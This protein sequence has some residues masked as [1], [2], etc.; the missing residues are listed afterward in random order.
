MLS[1]RLFLTGL[2]GAGLGAALGMPGLSFATIPG[3]ARF[4]LVILRGGMDGLAAFPPYADPH[5]RSARG[6]LALA[7]PGEENGVLDL[8][9]QFGM[10]P[11]LS[12]LHPFFQKQELL[13]F[14]AVAVAKPTRSHFDAQDILENGTDQAHTHDDG[15]LNRSLA[16]LGGGDQRLGLAV[17][18]DI[19]LV[20][21]GNTPVASWAPSR[22]A[23]APPGL[24][25]SL[26]FMYEDD[27]V[28]GPALRDG[29]RAKR[30]AKEALGESAPMS[31]GNPRGNPRSPAQFDKL[32]AAAG[33][34]LR[35]PSGAR[36]AVI[37]MNGWDTHANQGVDTGRLARN[38]GALADGLIK[39]PE[40]LGPEWRHT[41]VTVVTEFGRTVRMNGSRGTDHG[42]GGAA[43]LLGG[44]VAGGRMLTSWPGLSPQALY[45]DRD[46]A[47]S[48]D[49]RAIFKSVLHQHL[50]LSTSALE[51]DIFPNSQVANIS[52]ELIRG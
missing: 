46:L 1:R 11:A 29:R 21:R 27:P 40:Q 48:T 23:A 43:F 20:M 3:N 38:L 14:H 18:H 34:L 47:P 35:Q 13:L 17:G 52:S 8:D 32:T 2:A 44:A 45:E 9:G 6:K 36:I 15:W 37:D 19:P 7:A 31:R 42:T 50:G 22:L 41:V 16:A 25:D 26:E 30:M 24:L 39:L 51:Q 10:H 4:V 12:P 28:L 33:R 49:M 5:Y